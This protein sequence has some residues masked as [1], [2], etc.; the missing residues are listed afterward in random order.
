V[1][2]GERLHRCLTN[3]ES[4]HSDLRAFAIETQ[5]QQRRQVYQQLA[6]NMANTVS[7]LRSQVNA[8]ES[9]EPEYKVRAQPQ[10]RGQTSR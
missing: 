1:T 7:Q 5:D 8:V 3:A 6:N 9:A 4:V 10:Q 2:I